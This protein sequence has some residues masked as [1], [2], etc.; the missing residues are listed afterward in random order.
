MSI[1]VKTCIENENTKCIHV[2]NIKDLVSSLSIGILTLSLVVN[3][4]SNHNITETSLIV[5]WIFNI[6]IHVLSFI[7]IIPSKFVNKKSQNTVNNCGKSDKNRQKLQ[8]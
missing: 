6:H 4:F 2:E 5:Q 3:I 8:N 7:K 1:K